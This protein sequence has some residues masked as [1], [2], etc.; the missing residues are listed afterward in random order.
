VNVSESA[1]CPACGEQAEP[2]QDGDL[3]YFACD[4]GFEFGYQQEVQQD[5]SCQLGIDESI[6]RHGSLPDDGLPVLQIGRRP[7]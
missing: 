4:C 5:S 1:D 3:T 6:R 2:E 7:A